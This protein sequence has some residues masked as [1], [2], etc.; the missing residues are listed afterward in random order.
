MAGRLSQK[1]GSSTCVCGRIYDD[2]M[3]ING[4]GLMPRKMP[5]ER[6]EGRLTG[7]TERLTLNNVVKAIYM[8]ETKDC[9]SDDANGG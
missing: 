6:G 4:N 2:E 3:W 5:M 1:G 8:I 7:A 9:A